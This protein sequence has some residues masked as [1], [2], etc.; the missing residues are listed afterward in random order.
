[1]AKKDI[2]WTLVFLMIVLLVPSMILY[3]FTGVTLIEW[4]LVPHGFPMISI[5]EFLGG[6]MAVRFAIATYKKS[7]N[8]DDDEIEY[9]FVKF[10]GYNLLYVMTLLDNTSIRSSLTDASSSRKTK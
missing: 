2:N 4:F 5:P 9:V 10:I 6:S 7:N 1:M 8:D 3:G